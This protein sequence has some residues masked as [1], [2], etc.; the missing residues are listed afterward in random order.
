VFVT[1][2]VVCNS[3]YLLLTMRLLSV[4]GTSLVFV[5]VCEGNC[6]FVDFNSLYF[7]F[8]ILMC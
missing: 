2:G 8:V 1:V 5:F 3:L 7:V 6:V 4:C